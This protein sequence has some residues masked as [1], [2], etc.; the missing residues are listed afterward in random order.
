MPEPTDDRE[1]PRPGWPRSKQDPPGEKGA[2]GSVSRTDLFKLLL[3]SALGAIVT[4]L[5]AYVTIGQNVVH[6]DDLQNAIDRNSP[7]VR[8][9]E[10]ILRELDAQ[11]KYLA[12]MRGEL[13]Y[14]RDYTHSLSTQIALLKQELDR[15]AKDTGRASNP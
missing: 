9:R 10:A 15:H 2:N 5:G 6:S 13:N 8:D 4:G 1:P 12:E 11:S 3:A 14:L 7:Y